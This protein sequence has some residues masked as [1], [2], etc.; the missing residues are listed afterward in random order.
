MYGGEGS[1][2]ALK[3]P[4]FRPRRRRR[5]L[6]I[7][8][9]IPRIILRR[10]AVQLFSTPIMER[11]RHGRRTLTCHMRELASLCPREDFRVSRFR[12]LRREFLVLLDVVKAYCLDCFEQVRVTPREADIYRRLRKT[13]LGEK[14]AVTKVLFRGD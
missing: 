7:R 5:W 10:R 9:T 13:Q 14:R 4:V 12:A 8:H 2:G 3:K 6:E 11:G 1:P